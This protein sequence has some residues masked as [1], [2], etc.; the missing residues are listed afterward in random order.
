MS[1]VVRPVGWH[2]WAKPAREKT[3]RYAEYKSVGPGAQKET[4]VSWSRQLSA[5]E[6]KS[7]TPKKVLA[8]GDHWNPL[9]RN[10]GAAAKP[11]V[12]KKGNSSSDCAARPSLRKNVEYSRA[13]GESL[14]L[15]ACVPEGRGPFPAVI[16]VHGGGWSSGDKTQGVN[17]LFASI[18]GARLAWFSI[19]Y[20]QAPKH[21]YPASVEDVE[22]AIRWVKQHA[23]EFKVDPERL[24]L[25]GESAGGHLVALAVV[26]AKD[27]TRVAAA[28][29]FYAPVDLESDT[30]RRGG[31]SL[32]LR[33]WFGRSYEVN[34]EVTRLLSEASPINFVH[35]GLPPFLLV[36]GTADMS[37]PYSQ[38]VQMQVKLKAAGVACDLITI[39]DGVHGM[40]RWED[41]GY[42]H[43]VVKWL[44]ETAENQ[45]ALGCLQ[46]LCLKSRKQ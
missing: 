24:A 45:K 16:M 30:E 2:N 33:D 40:S 27:D 9:R 3:S 13:G 5:A 39:D 17:P 32:S 6:A 38:S 14:R 15:D 34:A 36:H 4:R 42:K 26:R 12:T 22:A 43:K 28:I 35:A 19:N 8:G 21:R 46:V 31:L 25:L 29:P 10:G 41:T 20:R 11:T 1:E 7:V 18:S 23:A 44:A 37:V